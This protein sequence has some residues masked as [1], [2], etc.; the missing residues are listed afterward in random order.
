MSE[1]HFYWTSP[2][3]EINS[4]ENYAGFSERSDYLLRV[5][6]RYVNKTDSI[7]ELGCNVGRNLEALWGAD[8]HNI[9]GVDINPRALELSKDLYPHM[10]AQLYHDIIE[11]FIKTCPVYDC[12]FTLAVLMHLPDDDTIKLIESKVGRVLITIED[13][14]TDGVFHFAR[15]YK[16]LFTGLQQIHT[17]KVNFIPPGL[18]TRVFVRGAL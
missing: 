10:K 11:D 7:L 4:P 14:C 1:C 12:I 17:E 2:P 9:Q 16:R 6:P 8:Y 13:E 5:L 18:T 3:D 15:N